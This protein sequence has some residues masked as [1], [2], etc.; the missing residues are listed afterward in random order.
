MNRTLRAAG[1]VLWLIQHTA[2]PKSCSGEIYWAARGSGKCCKKGLD[3]STREHFLHSPSLLTARKGSALRT[4][5]WEMLKGSNPLWPGC[6]CDLLCKDGLTNAV[7]QLQGCFIHTPRSFCIWSTHSLSTM[8]GNYQS[9]QNRS[10][11]SP[12]MKNFN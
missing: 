8:S 9:R 6:W 1:G 4:P 2:S 7:D 11:A 12:V 3:I 5:I 10:L